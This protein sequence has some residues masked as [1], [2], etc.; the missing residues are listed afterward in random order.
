M[1]VSPPDSMFPQS[2]AGGWTPRPRKPRPDRIRIESATANVA[3]TM[4]VPIALG[5]MCRTIARALPPPT[6]L[7]ACTYSL[8]RRLSVSPRTSRATPSQ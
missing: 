1:Y 2:V 7:T 3:C 8:V 4:I 5:T 6:T